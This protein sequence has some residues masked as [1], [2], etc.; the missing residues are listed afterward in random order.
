MRVV[1]VTRAVYLCLGCPLIVQCR[2]EADR[3]GEQY[4]VWGGRDRETRSPRTATAAW[5]PEEDALLLTDIPT[6]LIA[7]QLGRSRRAVQERRRRAGA[8]IPHL[9]HYT[10]DEDDLILAG[11]HPAVIARQTGRTVHSIRSRARKLR[12]R[13]TPAR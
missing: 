1:R 13:T 3:R 2:E 11:V 5:T 7:E 12:A 10:Q 8:G 9:A 6:A 4:G